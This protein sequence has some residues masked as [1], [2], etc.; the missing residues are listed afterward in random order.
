MTWDGWL[1]TMDGVSSSRTTTKG[2][3]PQKETTPQTTGRLEAPGRA[4]PS[5]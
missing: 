3:D 4:V 5:P 1:E 2:S